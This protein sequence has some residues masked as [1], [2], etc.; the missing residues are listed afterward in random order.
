VL[1]N[2]VFDVLDFTLGGVSG[3]KGGLGKGE[4]E[5]GEGGTTGETGERGTGEGGT[6]GRRDKRRREE[7]NTYLTVSCLS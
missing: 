1:G 5:I 4:G 7:L 2:S 6:R 3:P